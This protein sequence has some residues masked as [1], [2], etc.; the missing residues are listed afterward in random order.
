MKLFVLEFRSRANN[1]LAGVTLGGKTNFLDIM[2]LIY[3]ICNID[4]KYA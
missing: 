2:E 3:D 4:E 1:G